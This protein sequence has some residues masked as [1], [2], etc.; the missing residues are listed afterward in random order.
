MGIFSQVGELYN[1]KHIWCY[2]SLQDQQ[3]ARDVVWSK[4]Q[5]QWSEIVTH[6]RACVRNLDLRVQSFL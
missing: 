1:I 3:K 4:Q 2:D 6:T 5:M